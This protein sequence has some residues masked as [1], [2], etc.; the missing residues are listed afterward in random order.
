MFYIRY[1]DTLRILDNRIYYR[2]KQVSESL[3]KKVEELTIKIHN[4]HM[5]DYEYSYF[6]KMLF[7]G[8][9]SDSQNFIIQRIYEPEKFNVNLRMLNKMI[10]ELYCYK[11]LQESEVSS[12]NI[13]INIL[14]NVSYNVNL[15]FRNIAI[16]TQLR[17]I[18]KNTNKLLTINPLDL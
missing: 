10:I 2:R 12:S 4:K 3:S 9:M 14:R 15:F 13:C 6:K 11:L 7:K 18:I 5:E 16:K 1:L 17:Y 8:R